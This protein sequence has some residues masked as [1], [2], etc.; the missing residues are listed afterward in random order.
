MSKALQER[1]VPDFMN[2][3]GQEEVEYTKWDNASD[4][5]NQSRDWWSKFMH[6]PAQQTQP[7]MDADPIPSDSEPGWEV[8][9]P[10]MYAAGLMGVPGERSILQTSKGGVTEAMKNEEVVEYVTH[11][12]K[13]NGDPRKPPGDKVMVPL[14]LRRVGA[15]S[16]REYEVTFIRA[17]A[18]RQRDN[19]HANWEIPP[20]TLMKAAVNGLVNDRAV[21]VDH[22][23][24]GGYPSVA[25]LVGVTSNAQWS[26]AEQGIVGRV[27]LYGGAEW[28]VNL[29][30]EIIHDQA[31]G[32][33]VPDVGLSLVFYGTHQTQ[34]DRRVTTNIDYVE[35][36]DIVFGPAAE[37]RFK[38][39][40]S[41]DHSLTNTGDETKM[42]E[43]KA[44]VTGLADDP[45]AGVV[46]QDKPQETN[47]NPKPEPKALDELLGKIDQLSGAIADE[48]A[49]AE[50]SA[51]TA[52]AEK[53]ERLTAALLDRE[54]RRAVT[55]MGQAPNDR[56][57]SVITGKDQQDNF[58]SM[59]DWLFGV[60]GAEMPDP[61][62]RRS[63]RL[64]WA[65]TG[66]YEFR[67][68][69]DKR[70]VQLANANTTTLADMA[71]N[72]M[73]KVIMTQ[74]SALTFWRWFERIAAVT[75]ND[76]S[77]HDMAWVTFGGI[78][79]LPT[80]T[81]G[82]TYTELGVSDVKETDSFVKRG[83][84]VGVTREMIKNSDIQRI[85]AVPRALAIAA[86]RTRSAAV[87]NIFT[88]AAGLG[89]TLDQDATALFDAGHSNLGST[90]FAAAEWGVVR[91]AI[92]K[93]G[94]LNS[95]KALGVFPRYAL[96]PADL[97]DTAL[98]AFGYGQGYPTSYNVY[99]E[100]R[101]FED[102]RPVPLVVPDWTDTNNWAAIVDPMVFPVIMMS[103][104]QA[105][106]GGGHPIPELFSVV[107][108]TAGLMFTNDV[109]PIKVR[110]EFAV[111]VNG[112]RGIYKE[113]VA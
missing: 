23:D 113:N 19:S 60:P 24:L 50:T 6:P 52:L 88:T 89:P 72:A 44:V 68:V 58:Q 92:F 90:A 93:Q 69:F 102:P 78:G 110:D 3:G 59:I 109:M 11:Q 13:I 48:K 83:G 101:E 20:V 105:P 54:E 62:Y 18:I 51:V 74:F 4:V 79:N 66:D 30:D 107:N 16:A 46:S 77:V 57:M 67:G 80:V 39:A 14:A 49:E 33:P 36:V 99:A 21:F 43:N 7:F 75:P 111:G 61:Q 70:R 95:G 22:A 26:E 12:G 53:V 15:E 47:E 37:G 42:S 35:S 10:W 103:Y 40:L 17:G 5:Y 108:E 71:V 98:A 97:Y 87:S 94:E 65:L 34:G 31:A 29:L 1:P 82:G 2:E 86:L 45:Q 73:N 100:G 63:D 96:L 32:L 84:Y 112:Y 91:T 106:G 28:L 64:Y 27:R 56:L 85:Q 25:N 9:P 76:G 104:S 81:E 8:R 38:S 41:K 55:G